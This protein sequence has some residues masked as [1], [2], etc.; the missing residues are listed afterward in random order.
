MQA[1]LSPHPDFEEMS[2]E[3]LAAHK[4]DLESKISFGSKN[5]ADR[6][7]VVW[8]LQERRMCEAE[9][10]R[11]N[12]KPADRPAEQ[13]IFWPDPLNAQQLIDLPPDPT[14]WVWMECLPLRATS[15]LI[16]KSYTGKSTF[17]ASLALAV[18]R[19]MD[20]LGRPTQQGA[21]LYVYLDGPQDELKENFLRIGICGTDPLFTYAGKK[22]DRV[23]EWVKNVCSS[24]KVRLVIIDTAQKF[25]GFKE[26]RYEEKIN[27]MAP[28]LAMADENN[29]H[30]MFTYHAAKNATGTI[31]ALGSVASEANAR[32][33]L[34][35]RKK[36]ETNA[37]SV[38]LFETSQ[39][40][41]KRFETIGLSDPADGFITSVGALYTIELR[42]IG[43]MALNE[44]KDTPGITEP[45][46]RNRLH[47]NTQSLSRALHRLREQ[48]KVERIGRGIQGSPF[49]YFMAGEVAGI[50]NSP[51]VVKLFKKDFP[52]D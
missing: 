20:F 33:S 34:Y 42:E 41:G 11:R 35:L 25:F 7:I 10:A 32:V 28:M 45:D 46:I 50:A 5:G 29:F 51:K 52:S 4:K 13:Q 26:D 2:R 21:V 37:G 22:P 30:A 14:R 48:N 18:A 12:G 17:A 40:T 39:N 16:A 47:V 24:K 36:D 49:K 38:R 8:L 15:A 9:L 31:S 27:A 1:D 19:G 23:L 44:I 3:D 43:G 6:D